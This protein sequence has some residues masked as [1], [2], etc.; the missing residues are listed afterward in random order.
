MIKDRGNK[1]WSSLM[2]PEH[3]ELLESWFHEP[4]SAKLD[5]RQ[6]DEQQLEELNRWLLWSLQEKKNLRFTYRT[7]TGQNSLIGYV[8]DYDE[9]QRFFRIRQPSGKLCKLS[10]LTIVHISHA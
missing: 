4:S 6:M 3:R 5:H 2:L 9:I 7:P 8:E 1:K 10:S